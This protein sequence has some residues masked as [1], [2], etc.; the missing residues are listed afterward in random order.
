M[1]RISFFKQETLNDNLKAILILLISFLL[2][3]ALKYTTN[4][5]NHL[6]IIYILTV[7]FVSRLTVGYF[8]GVFYSIIGLITFNYYVF[9]QDFILNAAKNDY[10]ILFL[11]MLIISITISSMTVYIKKQEK[12]SAEREEIKHKLNQINNKLLSSNGTS[13]IINLTLNYVSELTKSTVVFYTQSPQL[14]H[15]CFIKSTC[16]EHEKI[17]NSSHEKFIAHWVFENMVPAG[18]DTDFCG[19]SSYTYLPLISHHKVWGVLGIYN[20]DSKSSVVNNLP[21]LDLIISQV[22]MALERQHLT[23]NQQQII[24]DTEKEKMRANLL[25]AVSHDLRTPLTGMIGASETLLNTRDSISVEEQN[26]LLEYIYEDSNWLL[27]MVENL[28]SVTRISGDNSSVKKSLEP[29]EEVVSE[30]ITRIQTRYPNASITAKIPD[31]FLMVPMDATLIEQVIINL[32]EN[33]IKHSKSTKPVELLV[34]KE[35]N[36]ILF[37]IVDYGIGIPQDNIDGIFDGFS[38]SNNHSSDT[39]KGLGIGLSICKTI[40][41]AHGGTLTAKNHG[42]SGAVFVFTLPAKEI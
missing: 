1:N 4:N 3:T 39:S 9:E 6:I 30:S 2:S 36:E 23:D 33:A 31:E 14:G 21:F 37:H 20:I 40:I 34:T 17:I 42:D 41:N 27:H 24:V 28:L 5:T 7:T 19:D 10:L 13:H 8:W 35:N 32:I 25:R 29:L 15:E 12:L 38:H 16:K 26:K 22:A 18:V 11:T